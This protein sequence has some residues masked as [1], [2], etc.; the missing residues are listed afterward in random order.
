[1]VPQRFI[2]SLDIS[3]SINHGTMKPSPHKDAI[4]LGSTNEDILR[5]YYLKDEV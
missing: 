1:M 5:S 2:D 4:L 3:E